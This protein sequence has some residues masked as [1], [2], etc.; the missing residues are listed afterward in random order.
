MK[1]GIEN[2]LARLYRRYENAQQV[3]AICRPEPVR[4]APEALQWFVNFNT[5]LSEIYYQY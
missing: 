1:G 3:E 4:E 2:D 5:E